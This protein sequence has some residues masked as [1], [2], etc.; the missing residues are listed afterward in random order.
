MSPTSPGPF[1]DLSPI[2]QLSI[3]LIKEKGQERRI[4]DTI[5]VNASVTYASACTPG[6]VELILKWVLLQVNRE[7]LQLTPAVP[8]PACIRIYLKEVHTHKKNTAFKK[9]SVERKPIRKALA[10]KQRLSSVHPLN[11]L[12]EEQQKEV[13]HGLK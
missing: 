4:T 9:S 10:S 5:A 6:S 2:G 7:C 12:V 11:N 8:A 1:W 13:M 3:K